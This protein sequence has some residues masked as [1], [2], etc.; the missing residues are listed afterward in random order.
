MG[1]PP[2]GEPCNNR[3]EC[4]ACVRARARLSVCMRQRRCHQKAM[5]RMSHQWELVDGWVR[6]PKKLCLKPGGRAGCR[7]DLP[8]LAQG[9]FW[10]GG[11]FQ[12]P[13]WC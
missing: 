8:A 1:Y 5:A 13:Q 2:L 10:G 3:R 6:I 11:G 9:S 7:V 4:S 12:P